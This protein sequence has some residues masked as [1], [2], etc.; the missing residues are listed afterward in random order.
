MT[1]HSEPAA[2]RDVE[3]AASVAR[4][5]PD[6]TD[7]IDVHC[8]IL[9]F[10]FVPDGFFKTKAPVREW[11]LRRKWTWA[12]ARGMTRLIPGAEYNRLDEVLKILDKKID[13][14]ALALKAEMED[15][16]IRASV[17]LMM[18]L[19][20]A[21]GGRPFDIEYEDQIILISRIARAHPGTFFPFIMIDP[22]RP[23]SY[24]RT[25]EALEKRGFLGVK[26]YPPLGYH[27]D[28]DLFY[29]ERHVSAEL[30]ALYDYCE[31]ED[32]P[33]TAHCSRG[34][35][36]ADD[37]M[38]AKPLREVYTRPRAWAG[39]LKRH[40]RLRLNLAHFGGDMLGPPAGDSWFHEALELLSGH[41]NL[42]LDV[43]YHDE[44]LTKTTAK[45]YFE[46]LVKLLD[47]ASPARERILLGTDWPMT[48]H[49]WTLDEYLRPF[50]DPKN[51]PE[52]LF[53][54]LACVNPKRFLFPSGLPDRLKVFYES[55]PA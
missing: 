47:N 39:V 16:G 43:S 8:H 20:Q 27:P 41:P 51:L 12:L 42:F 19:K 55:P 3:R 49:T 26:M 10:D 15:T 9:N 32:I 6:C 38:A 40:P 13:K 53:R 29:N 7:I 14:V 11:M 1:D 21:S 50:R 37:L 25:V 24:A 28:P 46:L 5:A 4:T 33:I 34:G 52:P 35:A 22:N 36:Y 45:P 2:P 44:A 23:Y 54:Q 31:S 17:P 30:D 18:D 48:R